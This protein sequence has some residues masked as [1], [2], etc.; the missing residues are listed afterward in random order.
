MDGKARRLRRIGSI[1]GIQYVY[2]K[3]IR[4]QTAARSSNN[5]LSHH[6]A[7]PAPIAGKPAYQAAGY[8]LGYWVQVLTGR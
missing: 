6:L 5:S 7:E 2:C 3:R 8:I 1:I 4:S